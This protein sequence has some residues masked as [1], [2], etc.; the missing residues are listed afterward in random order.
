MQI[1]IDKKT[2]I[3]NGIGRLV[4]TYDVWRSGPV[5]PNHLEGQEMSIAPALFAS[6]D[7]PAIDNAIIDAGVAAIGGA[8]GD[9]VTLMGGTGAVAQRIVSE[10]QS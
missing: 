7:P 10:P 2:A 3:V 4:V 5:D 9:R 6:A 1:V 8:P